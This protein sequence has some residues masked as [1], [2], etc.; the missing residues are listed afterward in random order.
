MTNGFE[1]RVSTTICK[2]DVVVKVGSGNLMDDA[3]TMVVCCII[4]TDDDA[5]AAHVSFLYLR[6]VNM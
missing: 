3:S 6:K 2:L 1:M 5:G 4:N